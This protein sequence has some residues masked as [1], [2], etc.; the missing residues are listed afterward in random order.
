MKN[1][2]KNVSTIREGLSKYMSAESI[3]NIQE[4][5]LIRVRSERIFKGAVGFE[6]FI[7]LLHYCRLLFKTAK[8][9][10]KLHIQGVDVMINWLFTII[11]EL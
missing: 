11:E 1:S 10:I 4:K 7:A 5:P 9:L 6:F 2:S 8:L 3:K